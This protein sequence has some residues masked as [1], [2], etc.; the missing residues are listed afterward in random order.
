MATDLT[1]A[2]ELQIEDQPQQTIVW[3]TGR[4]VIETWA[5]LSTTLRGLIP[6]GKPIRVDLANVDFVDSVGIGAFVSV[7][8]SARKAG[9]DLRFRNPNRRMQ[10]V[11]ALTKLYNLFEDQN[12]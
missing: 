8:A 5:K 10:D 12:A 1:P 9:C 3:C 11:V 6:E 4:V 7:W 2:L